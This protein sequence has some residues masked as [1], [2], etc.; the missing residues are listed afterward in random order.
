MSSFEVGVSVLTKRTPRRP[1]E[2][3]PLQIS[4]LTA[5]IR[6]TMVTTAMVPRTTPNRVSN[7]RILCAQTSVNVVRRASPMTI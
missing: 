6:L 3:I 2:S 1:S 5:S 4:T 7:D